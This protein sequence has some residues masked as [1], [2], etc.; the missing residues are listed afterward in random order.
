MFFLADPGTN[1]CTDDVSLVIS[2]IKFVLNVIRFI[3]PIVLILL[4]TI[5]LFKAVTSQKDDEIKKKSSALVKRVIAGV[6]VFL[7][8]TIVSLLMGWIGNDEWSNCWDDAKGDFSALFE[9]N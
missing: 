3:I 4:G 9:K 8:P 7:I 1:I 6:V 2:L 5:D